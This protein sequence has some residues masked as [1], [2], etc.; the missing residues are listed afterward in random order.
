MFADQR[1]NN[2]PTQ[3][4]HQELQQLP[5]P[6]GQYRQISL[7]LVRQQPYDSGT[8]RGVEPHESVSSQIP[9]AKRSCGPCDTR[10]VASLYREL[11]F[12]V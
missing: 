4:H 6:K 1:N 12:V 3:A 11:H 8:E 10:H 5:K 2:P 9:H 7:R